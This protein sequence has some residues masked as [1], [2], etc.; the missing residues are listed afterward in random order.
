M[1]AD[2]VGQPEKSAASHSASAL[3]SR[4]RLRRRRPDATQVKYARR[5]AFSASQC[6]AGLPE[7]IQPPGQQ[8]LQHFQVNGS[9][10][11]KASSISL[12]THRH[13]A[14]RPHLALPAQVLARR[15]HLPGT[16]APAA[17]LPNRQRAA[18]QAGLASSHGVA[19][20]I[21]ANS[22][23]RSP[24]STSR[25]R[26]LRSIR[27]P[28]HSLEAP[29]ALCRKRMLTTMDCEELITKPPQC[30]SCNHCNHF[31]SHPSCDSLPC[32]IIGYDAMFSLYRVLQS[33]RSGTEALMPERGWIQAHP[34]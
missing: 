23:R 26:R 15:L 9:C 12:E 24:S 14:L 33:A 4:V 7:R 21:K 25:P 34:G 18:L 1:Q 28:R 16:H 13:I 20:S 3:T 30:N 32:L 27:A 31:A 19:K 17:S 22:E 2:G 29:A 5:A 6:L 11:A 10:S 8:A